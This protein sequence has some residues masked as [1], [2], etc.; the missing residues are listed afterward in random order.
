[1]KN[2]I[3]YFIAASLSNIKNAH[4]L[5]RSF[6]VSVV[7]MIVNNCTFFIIWL[8]F[9][10]ATGPINGWTSI[11][12]FGMLGIGI[13]TYGITHA[14]FYGLADLPNLIMKGSFDGILLSP[15]SAVIKLAG[16]SFS[17]VAFGDILQGTSVIAFYVIYSGFGISELAVF[18]LMVCCGAIIFICM[19]LLCSLI[20]FYVHDGDV[21]A[22]QIFDMFLRPTMYPGS[23]FPGKLR[24]FF[25]TVVPALLTSAVPIFAIKE[26]SSSIV[27]FTV[28]ATGV[29]V[30]I[31]RVCFG[32][33]VRRYESG[34]FLR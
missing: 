12:V 6:W 34:N 22:L 9:M 28:C 20:A 11:D 13:L 25:M 33:A 31:A 29:W 19:R 10:H 15:I 32:R 24:V 16:A 26:H 4:A 2:D 23:I 17:P 27:A 14:F 3:R 18:A 30:I 8:L 1:M 7:S 21:I 5:T